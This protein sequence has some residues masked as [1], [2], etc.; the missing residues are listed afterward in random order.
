MANFLG[1]EDFFALGDSSMDLNLL[2]NSKKAYIP[3]NSFLMNIEG[4][5]KN[6]FIPKEEGLKGLEE[7]LENIDI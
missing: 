7:I 1:Y 4:V 3:K 6:I 2:K 5:N